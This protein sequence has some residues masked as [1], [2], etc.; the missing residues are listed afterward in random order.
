MSTTQFT[1]REIEIG[2]HGPIFTLRE[3]HT[4]D[5]LRASARRA[6]DHSKPILCY[7]K[8]R[9]QVV[10]DPYRNDDDLLGTVLSLISSVDALVCCKRC[11]RVATRS[12][13]PK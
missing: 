1:D 2:D 12:N 11:G 8:H 10:G 5:S 9:N 3:P 6:A 7:I 13:W 4:G